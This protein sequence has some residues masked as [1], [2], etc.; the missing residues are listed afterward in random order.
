LRTN[1]DNHGIGPS[2]GILGRLGERAIVGEKA[3]RL[4]ITVPPNGFRKEMSACGIAGLINIDGKRENGRKVVDMI[5]TMLERENGLGAGYA[6]YGLFPEMKEH[7]CIQLLLDDMQS[8]EAVEDFLVERVEVHKDEEVFTRTMKGMRG[9][10]PLIWRFF[11]EVPKKMID[12]NPDLEGEDDYIVN[13]VMEI[14]SKIS[15]AFCMSSGKDMAVFKGNG[16]SH[17][18]AEFYDLERYSGNMWLSHSRFPTNTP[19]WWGGAHPFNILDWSLCHNGEITSYGTNKRYVE[20]WGYKCTMLTDS[21]VVTYLWDLL[22]RRHGLPPI[23]ASMAVAPRYYDDIGRLADEKREVAMRLRRTYANAMING[24]F[25]ILVGKARPVPTLIALTDRKKLR[26]M[27][28]GLSGDEGTVFAA[29]EECAIR[30]VERDGEIWAPVAGNPLIAR[31]GE[32]I[33]WD[34]L[35]DQFQYKRMKVIA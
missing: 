33:I 25:S 19:G 20:M 28:G 14:N 26:P 10:Y 2:R 30:R 9:P 27:I 32:G 34:G 4:G 3:G 6:C 29:S 35:K 24:P 1:S 12:K 23:V 8:K 7:Y 22:C 11:L 17:D 16:W 21:E 18:I 13:L 5:T 31:M 15:G